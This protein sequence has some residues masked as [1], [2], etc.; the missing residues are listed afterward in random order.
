[1]DFLRECALALDAGEDA[2]AVLAR[3]RERYTTARCLA[4]KTC[5]VR[6]MC[7]DPSP[8]FCTARD[9][10]LASADADVAPRLRAALDGEEA[11]EDV[12]ALLATLPPRLAPNVRALRVSRAEVRE[13]KRLSARSAV[14]KNKTVRDV[15]GRSLLA[16]ARGIV[17]GSDGASVTTL[18]LALMVLTGRRTCEVLNGRSGVEAVGEHTVRF[19]GQAKR[20]RADEEGY[21]VPTLCPAADV[22]ATL[23]VLRAKQGHCQLTNRQTSRRYQSALHQKLVE[24]SGPWTQCGCVHGLRGA[25]AC[26]ALRLFEWGSRSPAYVTMCILGH[27][28]LHESLVYT[29]MRLGDAFSVEP[30]LGEGALTEREEEK[31]G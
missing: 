5:L 8:A 17:A 9:A 14:Q 21:V 3:M 7:A 10:L 13:V 31:T 19:V 12:R 25:Y 26:M 18:A 22:V 6:K 16:A 28:G 23:D 15:D 1:M 2:E 24:W 4:V 29:T 20:R 30:T 11:D 27:V